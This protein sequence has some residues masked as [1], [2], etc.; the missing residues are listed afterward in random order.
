[1]IYHAKNFE[2]TIF[3]YLTFNTII[4]IFYW[5]V[6]HG[7]RWRPHRNNNAFLLNVASATFNGHLAPSI[8]HAQNL[9]IWKFYHLAIKTITVP[10]YWCILHSLS[11][12]RIIKV[13]ALRISHNPGQTCWHKSWKSSKLKKWPN[14]SNS[15]FSPLLTF[16]TV[17]FGQVLLSKS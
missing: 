14:F 4:F 17:E 5:C 7:Q 13:Y 12:Y 1:M 3:Y 10:S 15:N 2:L 9:R 16:I 11:P 8:C 6:N